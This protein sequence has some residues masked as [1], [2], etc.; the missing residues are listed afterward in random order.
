LKNVAVGVDIGGSQVKLV[1]V[2]R[3]RQI[4]RRETA[5]T[6]GGGAQPEAIVANIISATRRLLA[7]LPADTAVEGYGFSVPCYAEGEDWVLG[8][9]TNLPS[10]E[11]FPLRPP[12]A[13]AFGAHIATTYD[14]NAAGLAEFLWGAGAGCE[15]MFFMGIGT[16]ISASFFTA[17]RGMVS[18]TYDTLGD[19]GHLIVAPESG[20]L[21]PCGGHGCLEAVASAPAIRKLALEAARTGRSAHLAEALAAAGDLS[22]RDAAAAARA[23]DPAARAIFEQIGRYLGIALASYLHIFAPRRIVLGGGVALAGD[24]LLDPLRRT[25]L[26][27]ASPWYL[28]HFEG[29]VPS[30]FGLEAG[31]IGSACQV[32]YPN[33]V[34]HSAVQEG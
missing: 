34:H 9:V 1:A 3:D 31:A 29:I 7:G 26:A 32:F 13:E 6:L 2:D 22:A 28:K 23:G 5:A 10:L 33:V 30:H 18:Y 27:L 8:E 21:C 20:V 19:T 4:Y 24:T 15:R 11:G 16:G 14:T 17:Q 12:L 25:F